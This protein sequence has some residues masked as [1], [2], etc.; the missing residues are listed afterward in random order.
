MSDCSDASPRDGEQW[1][2]RVCC[3]F[4]AV[5]KGISAIAYVDAELEATEFCAHEIKAAVQAEECRSLQN[6][7]SGCAPSQL[8]TAAE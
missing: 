4:S 8:T 5:W 6:T 7:K 1:D 2:S 3:S